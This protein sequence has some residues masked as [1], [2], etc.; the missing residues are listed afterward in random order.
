MHMHLTTQMQAEFE[1][2]RKRL[3]VISKQIW[4]PLEMKLMRR[5]RIT[6][7]DINIGQVVL[8]EVKPYKIRL[9]NILCE[10]DCKEQAHSR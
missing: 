7:E 2:I 8:A 5:Y 10:T 3:D 1:T 6:P 9:E 4:I